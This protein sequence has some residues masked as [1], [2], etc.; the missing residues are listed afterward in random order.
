MAELILL[1]AFHLSLLFS[2]CTCCLLLPLL[3]QCSFLHKKETSL[4][5]LTQTRLH[6]KL[7]HAC[8]QMHPEKTN[9]ARKRFAFLTC[10]SGTSWTIFFWGCGERKDP[11][12]INHWKPSRRQGLYSC[13][14]HLGGF[15]HLL[16]VSNCQRL[17]HTHFLGRPRGRFSPG[18]TFWGR[19]DGFVKISVISVFSVHLF[20]KVPIFLIKKNIE[21]SPSFNYIYMLKKIK[22]SSFHRLHQP[23]N[24][25][26]IGPAICLGGS[27]TM[28][29]Q[30]GWMWRRYWRQ[31]PLWHHKG[32]RMACLI[33]HLLKMFRIKQK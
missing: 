23:W 14:R 2:I 8:I 6:R 1:S 12:L 11:S 15:G 20:K 13:S 18:S 28:E 17:L 4:L 24:Y 19:A 3:L 16:L 22:K 31:C 27:I 5:C 9:K 32:C 25:L 29:S 33:H 30:G 21:E 26:H 7:L 10:S